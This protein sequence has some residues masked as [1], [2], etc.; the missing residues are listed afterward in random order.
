M[1][2]KEKDQVPMYQY[3][4]NFCTYTGSEQTLDRT[5]VIS[6]YV[7][8]KYFSWCQPKAEGQSLPFV[9]MIW[10]ASAKAGV[11]I[12]KDGG[13]TYYVVVYIALQDANNVAGNVP[14]VKGTYFVEEK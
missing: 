4:V 2:T 9:N 12:A 8:M 7:S 6:W 13:G 14:P 1:K 11:G 5:C 10:K 3:S